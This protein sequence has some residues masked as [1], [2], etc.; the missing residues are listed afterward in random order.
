MVC[1]TDT[2]DLDKS[3]SFELERLHEN[4]LDDSFLKASDHHVVWSTDTLDFD[5]SSSFELERLHENCLDDNFF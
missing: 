2:L 3:S 5:K 1:S 4:C